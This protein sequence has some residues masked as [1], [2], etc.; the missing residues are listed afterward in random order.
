MIRQIGRNFKEAFQGLFRHFAMASSSAI[1]ITITLIIV[2]A[3]T[4]IIG[5]IDR[6][7]TSM[8]TEIQIY[9]KIDDSIADS[10]IGVLQDQVKAISGVAEVVYSSA[11][12]ELDRFIE[13]Y[14]EDGSIFEIYR[15][16][17]PLSRVF[18]V[19]VDSNI[20][21]LSTVA[22]KM[23]ALVGIGE[24]DYGGATTEDFITVL[25]G[26]RKVGYII[27]LA[28]TVLAVFLI[29]N[30]IN[31]TIDARKDELAIMRFVGASNAYIRNPLVLE[32]IFIGILGS[33]APVLLTIFGYNYLYS[34]FDGKL[35]TGMLKLME[36]YPFVYM[37]AGFLVILGVAVGLV[38][39]FLAASKTLRWKR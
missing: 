18:L 26:T 20:A 22:A 27:V 14:G 33:I 8:E 12:N 2:S 35:V 29:Y 23:E 38:G 6:I 32:G 34:S 25:N 39:S 28:M 17:N 7:S 9:A 31:L 37:V 24:V 10:D 19:K 5:N 4:M 36:P 11:D 15:E 30:T 16:D 1:A 13:A 21:S 3:L